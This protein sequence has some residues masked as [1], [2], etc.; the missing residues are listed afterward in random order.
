MARKLSSAE[1]RIFEEVVQ[2]AETSS[3]EVS[4]ET[5][6]RRLKEQQ[7]APFPINQLPLWLNEDPLRQP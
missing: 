7:E 6:L 4:S 5:F 3:V 2:E 1:R